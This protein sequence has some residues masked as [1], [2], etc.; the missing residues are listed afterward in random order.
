MNAIDESSKIFA[1]R[2]YRDSCTKTKS[3]SLTKTLKSL[4]NRDLNQCI[5]VDDNEMHFRA[6]PGNC[7][8]VEEFEIENEKHD[9][10]I[11]LQDLTAL[12]KRLLRMQDFCRVLRKFS[13]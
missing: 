8:L 11:E 7:I 12:L 4:R 9:V 13:E 5:L 6:N 1:H 2:L 3:G 10:D